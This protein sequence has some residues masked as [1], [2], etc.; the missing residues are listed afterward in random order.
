MM[1]LRAMYCA[2]LAPCCL[3][4]MRLRARLRARLRVMTLSLR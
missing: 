2:E 4:R 1:S 3:I